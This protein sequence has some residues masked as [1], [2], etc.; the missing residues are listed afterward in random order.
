VCIDL[1]KFVQRSSGIFGATG[2]GKSCLTRILLAGLIHHNSASVLILDMHNEYGFDDTASDTG[3]SVVGLRSKFPGRVRVVGLGRETKIRNHTPDF[4][5]EIHESDIQ[6]KILSC[7]AVNSICVK[8]PP[9]RLMRWCIT[10]VTKLVS[11]VQTDGRG[12]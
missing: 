7:S 5:L 6:R 10:L 4:H 1:N 12:Q 11:R 3:K 9:P 8:P 2:T